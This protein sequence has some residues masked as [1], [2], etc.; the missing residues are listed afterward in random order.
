MI[1]NEQ[2]RI[3]SGLQ[4]SQFKENPLPQLLEQERKLHETLEFRKLNSKKNVL[5]N[6]ETIHQEWSRYTKMIESVNNIFSSENKKLL[7]DGLF[8]SKYSTI[9]QLFNIS[10]NEGMSHAIRYMQDNYSVLNNELNRITYLTETINHDDYDYFFATKDISIEDLGIEFKIYKNK[11]LTEIVS[12]TIIYGSEISYLS[13]DLTIIRS[14]GHKL[15]TTILKEQ[16][17]LLV[18]SG[19]II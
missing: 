6:I 16:F 9:Q 17:D 5:D 15:F 18:S 10:I 11:D 8:E 3:L 7:V 1:L 12:N 19:F 2:L 14:S 4:E 13:D